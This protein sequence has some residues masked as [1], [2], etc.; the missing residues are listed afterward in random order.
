MRSFTESAV[1][2]VDLLLLLVETL[3]FLCCN[4]EAL[5]GSIEARCWCKCR[6][7]KGTLIKL[8]SALSEDEVRP[9]LR[10]ARSVGRWINDS[11]DSWHKSSSQSSTKEEEWPSQGSKEEPAVRGS[12]TESEE[13]EKVKR[14]WS[15]I[16]A[17][18]PVALWLSVGF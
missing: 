10:L 1:I 11:N 2:P 15:S 14:K 16:A 17:A 9:R 12:L 5:P 13:E 18:S 8:G 7:F 3:V 4:G 6:F